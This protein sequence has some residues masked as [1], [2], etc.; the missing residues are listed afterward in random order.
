[1]SVREPLPDPQLKVTYYRI[2]VYQPNVQPVLVY[3]HCTSFSS[4][5]NRRGMSFVTNIGT[6]VHTTLPFLAEEEP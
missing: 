2:T 4:S 3:E 1:M 5:S 6:N